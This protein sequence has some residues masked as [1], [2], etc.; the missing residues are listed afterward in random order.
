MNEHERAR[1]TVASDLHGSTTTAPGKRTLTASLPVQRRA[2]AAT[3]TS[4]PIATGGGDALPGAVR[5]RFEGSFGVDLGAVRV[6]QDGAAAA[7]GAEAFTQGTSIHM[8]P[9]RYQPDS[10]SGLELLGHEVAH[11]VQQGEGRVAAS[12]QYRGLGLNDDHALEAEADHQG[13]LA[14]QGLPARTGSVAAPGSLSPLHTR[15]EGPVQGYFTYRGKRL[16]KEQ[17]DAF[18]KYLS[19]ADETRLL[20]KFE[21]LAESKQDEGTIS[22]YAAEHD[23][24]SPTSIFA[25]TAHVPDDDESDGG[26]SASDDDEARPA[27]TGY[28]SDGISDVSD[29]EDETLRN[30][31]DGAQIDIKSHS[32]ASTRNYTAKRIRSYRAT[33][34]KVAKDPVADAPT[35]TRFGSSMFLFAPNPTQKDVGVTPLVRSASGDHVER[36]GSA[37]PYAT[38]ATELDGHVK[39]TGATSAGF[40]ACLSHLLTKDSNADLTKLRE[41]CPK[42]DAS[43]LDPLREL[44]AILVSDCARA[45]QAVDLILTEALANASF[46][47]R[48]K[49]G[50]SY[51]G[52]KK[53]GGSKALQSYTAAQKAGDD[54]EEDDD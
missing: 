54:D 20:T 24:P 45:G 34:K 31:G 49:D 48:F 37:R 42:L 8:A 21:D 26:G 47:S 29:G 16:D 33:K 2:S 18:R 32:V 4:E 40:N 44:A 13:A 6:H 22:D 36:K 10:P 52:A 19:D 53:K 11:V 50:G 28:D 14:A 3:A 30:K 23:L 12:R 51:R 25:G 46:V 35:M 7:M 17:I 43:C 38:L 9:G 27:I 1:A 41:L 39:R 5:S 15:V